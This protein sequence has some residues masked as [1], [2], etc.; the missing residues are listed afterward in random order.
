VAVKSVIDIDV[1]DAHFK[2]FTEL[3]NKYRDAVAKQPEAWKKVGASTK[4][5]S[6]NFETMAAA[7]MAQSHM[8]KEVG[9]SSDQSNK[10]LTRQ[11]GLWNTIHRST[12]GVF[13]NVTGIAKL[14]TE[15]GIGL[16]LG[17][18]GF[19]IGSLFGLL[20]MG[21]SVSN[22]R[23]AALGLGMSIGQHQ[24]FNLYQGRNLPGKGDTVLSAALQAPYAGSAAG[25]LTNFLGISPHGGTYAVADSELMAVQRY[26][27]GKSK[28]EIAAIIGNVPFISGAG[29]DLST[30]TAL[31]H[32][33]PGELQGLIHQ[34]TAAAPGL[35]MSNRGAEGWQNFVSR[36]ETDF[37][38]MAKSIE[39]SFMSSGL[40]SPIERLMRAVTDDIGMFVKSP[41]A[42][43]ALSDLTDA[44]NNFAKYISGGGFT[45]S[46]KNFG[47]DVKQFDTA[48][49]ITGSVLKV[50]AWPFIHAAK[51]WFDVGKL[52]A[53][54]ANKIASFAGQTYYS[55]LHTANLN[56]EVQALKASGY[57]A[58]SIPVEVTAHSH[59]HIKI[60]KP[61]GSSIHAAVNAGH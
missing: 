58:G 41:L 1:N 47:D 12:T 44:L 11:Q 51:G 23:N 39:N 29:F 46:I 16:G 45:Q 36:I 40:L 25:R 61:A 19:G 14:L 2:R 17:A 33:N 5:T 34:G 59:L 48:V 42:K 9:R 22:Q 8:A 43:K 54:E 20:G 57:K 6:T 32:L 38:T 31:E 52:T 35:N 37:G 4:S 7:M 30:V 3:F 10:T 13:K 49:S 28:S 56:A 18:L 50:L 60:T 21:K 27:H 15:M 53:K 55:G 26:F 24:A